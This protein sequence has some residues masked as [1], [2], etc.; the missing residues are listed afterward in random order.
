MGQAWGAGVRLP[1][2]SNSEYGPSV[3]VAQSAKRSSRA[4]LYV[5]KRKVRIPS[6]RPFTDQLTPSSPFSKELINSY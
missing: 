4:G 3:L 6:S 1:H 5:C 2:L